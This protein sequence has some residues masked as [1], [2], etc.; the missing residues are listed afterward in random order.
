MNPDREIETPNPEAQD[1]AS[2]SAPGPASKPANRH[3]LIIAD[4]QIANWGRLKY[5]QRHLKSHGSFHLQDQEQLCRG[6]PQ[7]FRRHTIAPR[8]HAR[9]ATCHAKH[10]RQAKQK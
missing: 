2:K 3:R 6:L 8:C 10:K 9:H 7:A 5:Q 1:K 4:S